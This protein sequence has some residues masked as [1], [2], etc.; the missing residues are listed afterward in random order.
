MRIYEPAPGTPDTASMDNWPPPGDYCRTASGEFC[1][2]FDPNDEI[3]GHKNWC[4]KHE[5][6]CQVD[7]QGLPDKCVPCKVDLPRL[8]AGPS[9]ATG[10]TPGGAWAKPGEGCDKVKP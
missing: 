6:Q 9:R 3:M 1:V 7:G 10:L 2:H 5:A 4:V 8:A